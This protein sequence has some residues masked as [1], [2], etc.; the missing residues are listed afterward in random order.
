[1]ITCPPMSAC[2]YSN[3]LD[4]NLHNN[5]F[6]VATYH[7]SS[8]FI[9]HHYIPSF[10]TFSTQHITCAVPQFIVLAWQFSQF[11]EVKN[12]FLLPPTSPSARY[13]SHVNVQCHQR[14]QSRAVC[15]PL[16]SSS[17]HRTNIL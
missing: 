8:R 11:S 7:K 16:L 13:F 3:P 1:M 15:K 9:T 17:Q 12:Y 14:R 6:E 4:Y 2:N 10:V 5:L